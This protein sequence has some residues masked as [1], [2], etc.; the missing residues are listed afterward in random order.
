MLQFRIILII[1]EHSNSTRYFDN[2]VSK[3]RGKYSIVCS[4]RAS[5]SATKRP[6]SNVEEANT[7]PQK[8]VLAFKLNSQDT[9]DNN[10]LMANPSVSPLRK[11]AVSS[12]LH[13]SQSEKNRLNRIR[14]FKLSHENCNLKGLAADLLKIECNSD[15][16][17]RSLEMI[18]ACSVLKRKILANNFKASL[19]GPQ[20][21]SLSKKKYRL[22]RPLPENENVSAEFKS[23]YV[24]RKESPDNIRKTSADFYMSL[25]Q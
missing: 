18:K 3:Y 22:P 16:R 17:D 15:K 20:H 8:P 7:S 1:M 21:Q 14:K 23:I 25:R 6:N 12:Y 4:G 2:L 9:L 5:T 24:P 13:G 10:L 11:S 19:S